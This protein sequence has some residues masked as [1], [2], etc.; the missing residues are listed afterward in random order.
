MSQGLRQLANSSY[1]SALDALFGMTQWLEEAARQAPKSSYFSEELP[2][3]DETGDFQ[4]WGSTTLPE[5]TQAPTVLDRVAINGLTAL[6][7]FAVAR[8]GKKP[9]RK[10]MV[11]G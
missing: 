9:E 1:A 2:A 3:Q 4:G 8:P 7:M 11:A 6:A 10:S 5:T